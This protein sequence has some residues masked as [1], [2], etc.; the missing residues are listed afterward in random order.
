MQKKVFSCS[1]VSRVKMI[2]WQ[3]TIIYNSLGQLLPT[4]VKKIYIK[5][6]TYT[7]DLLVGH[8]N[9]KRKNIAY[10]II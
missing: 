1:N 8:A 10:F 6:N 2:I 4:S 3:Q 5:M 9:E 7:I